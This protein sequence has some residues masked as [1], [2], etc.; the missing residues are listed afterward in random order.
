M[1]RLPES[2]LG[3][4]ANSF[5][6]L[7]HS[8]TCNAIMSAVEGNRNASP[9]EISVACPVCVIRENGKEYAHDNSVLEIPN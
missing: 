9:S 5:S 4:K 3:K 7:N 8:R 1:S 2:V 6:R